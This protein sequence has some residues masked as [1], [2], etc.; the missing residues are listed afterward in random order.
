MCKLDQLADAEKG[1]KPTVRSRHCTRRI[2]IKLPVALPAT[3]DGSMQKAEF[4]K[5]TPS[6]LGLIADSAPTHHVWRPAPGRFPLD[7]KHD[8]SYAVL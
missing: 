4:A 7:R 5:L 8:P 3:N 6:P 1:G 2:R